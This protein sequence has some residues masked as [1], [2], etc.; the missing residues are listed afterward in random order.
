MSTTK[1]SSNK[2]LTLIW[3]ILLL[4]SS[5]AAWIGEFGASN[6]GIV[7]F[8]IVALI[9][10]GQLIIDHF[11]GLKQSPLL[12]RGIMSAFCIVISLIMFITYRLQ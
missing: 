5:I 11:M 6:T 10:K 9:I 4:L 1:T 12:W 2:Q 8:V 3:L 7:A